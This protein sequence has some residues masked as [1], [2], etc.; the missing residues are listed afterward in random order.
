MKSYSTTITPSLSDQE[1]TVSL[2]VTGKKFYPNVVIIYNKFDKDILIKLISNND[3]ED[4]IDNPTHYAYITLAGGF[5]VFSEMAQI[6]TVIVKA[7]ESGSG[8]VIVQS[9]NYTEIKV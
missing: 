9:T 1:A 2:S 4:I 3:A 8:T 7:S 5:H 6:D